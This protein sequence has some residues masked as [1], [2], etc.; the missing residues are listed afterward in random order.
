[1]CSSSIKSGCSWKKAIIVLADSDSDKSGRNIYLDIRVGRGKGIN[2]NTVD[3]E[4][5]KFSGAEENIWLLERI[6]G[7]MRKRGYTITSFYGEALK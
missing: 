1:M 7:S 6:R 4:N 3:R 5:C 2:R